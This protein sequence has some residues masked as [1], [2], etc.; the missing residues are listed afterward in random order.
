[1]LLLFLLLKWS[2]LVFS[3]F[4]TYISDGEVGVV[5]I[6]PSLFPS[7]DSFRSSMTPFDDKFVISST[8]PFHKFLVNI[9]LYPSTF[10]VHV[11]K[12]PSELRSTSSIACSGVNTHSSFDLPI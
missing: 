8:C 12:L 9:L 10:S 7:G 6:I 5:I 4:K 2:S 11:S 1:M 3:I